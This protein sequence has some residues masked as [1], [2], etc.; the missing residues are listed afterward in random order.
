MEPLPYSVKQSKLVVSAKGP[1]GK[2]T[3]ILWGNRTLVLCAGCT[4]VQHAE[5]MDFRLSGMIA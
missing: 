2:S 4:A 3:D 1:F 5:T